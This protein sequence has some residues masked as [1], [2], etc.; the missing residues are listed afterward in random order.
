MY[1]AT[2]VDDLKNKTVEQ[3]K[4]IRDIGVNE[5]SLGV[6][7]GDDWTLQHINKGYTS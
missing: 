4:A 3:L 7:N 1:A 6:E 5:I 2:R